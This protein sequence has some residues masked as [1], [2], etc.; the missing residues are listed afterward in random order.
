LLPFGTF[1][2]VFW[3]FREDLVE[4]TCTETMSLILMK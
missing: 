4:V 3:R 1:I 2:I